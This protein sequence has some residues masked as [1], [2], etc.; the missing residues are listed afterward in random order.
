MTKKHTQR[1]MLNVISLR[2]MQ[3]LHKVLQP[4]EQNRQ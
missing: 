2:E 4:K 3:T 1:K